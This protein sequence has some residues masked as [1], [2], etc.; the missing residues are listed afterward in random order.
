MQRF[1]VLE[2]VFGLLVGTSTSNSN[3]TPRSLLNQLLSL[4]SR[5]NDLSDIIRFGIID[6]I[7]RKIDLLEFLE[8]F[9]IVRRNESIIRKD[10][11]F[12]HLHA[13]LNQRY[14][15]PHK[16]VS[17]SDLS[18]VDSL[19]SVVVDGF[20]AGGSQIGVFHIEVV[21]LRVELIESVQS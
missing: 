7:I 12:S 6:R 11:R 20:W 2:D 17:F 21:H 15:F 13:I 1:I 8:W 5:S 4:S 19:A 10:L 9:I 16:G 3:L 18:C 14:S